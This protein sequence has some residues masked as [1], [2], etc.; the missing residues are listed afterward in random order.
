MSTQKIKTLEEIIAIRNRLKEAGRKLV[1]ALGAF[2][3][4]HVGHVR[5]LNEARMQGDVLIVGIYGDRSIQEQKGS[6]Y[7][8]VP[9]MERAEVIA[10][11]SSVD[12]IFIYD[13]TGHKPILDSLVPDIVIKSEE[14]PLKETVSTDSIIEKV[15]TEFGKTGTSH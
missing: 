8:I 7:P 10:A 11:L 14:Q 5:C 15:L 13:D 2:D 9:E 4:L 6:A 3:I 12:Y 1:L